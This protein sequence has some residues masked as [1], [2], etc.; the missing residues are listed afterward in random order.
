MNIEEQNLRDDH[1]DGIHFSKILSL[2]PH[3]NK[4]SFETDK[5][6][7]PLLDGEMINPHLTSLV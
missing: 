6:N 1:L 4:E 7:E 2:M 3:Y 5:S